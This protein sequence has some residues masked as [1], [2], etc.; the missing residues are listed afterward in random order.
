MYLVRSS[1]YLDIF[2][3]ILAAAVSVP[4]VLSVAEDEGTVQVC[5]TLFLDTEIGIT[6]TL[7]TSDGSINNQPP[8]PTGKGSLL[9][10]RFS[11]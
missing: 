2:V 10:C 4:A 1:L 7:A 5:A 9:E 8:K 6:V 3:L 11:M